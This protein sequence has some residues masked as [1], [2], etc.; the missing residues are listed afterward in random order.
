LKALFSNSKEKGKA[1]E[2]LFNEVESDLFLQRLSNLLIRQ[3]TE[4]EA[5][6]RQLM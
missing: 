1:K 3:F 5:M 4:Q 2:I 6:L